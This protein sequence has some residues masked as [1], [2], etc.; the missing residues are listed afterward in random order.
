VNSNLQTSQKGVFLLVPV[1]YPVPGLVPFPL[2]MAFL[3]PF[4]TFFCSE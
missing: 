2:S 3:F 1:S 4:G